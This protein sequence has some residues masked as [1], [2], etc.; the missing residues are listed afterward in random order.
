MKITSLYIKNYK[1]IR[2]I[3]IAL[4]E[5]VNVFIGENSVGKSNIFSAID[6]MLGPV[7]PSFNNFAKED[8]YRG[9]TSAHVI[10]RIHFDDNHYLELT[11][12]WHDRYGNPKS[13]LNLDGNQY[14]SDDVRQKYISALIGP[15]RK[16]SDN[17]AA[18]RWTLLGRLL[19]D[20]NSRFMEETVFDFD[21]LEE[22]EKSELFKKEM[23]R[24]R[25]DILFSVTDDEG[26]NLMQ[27]FVSILGTETAKQLN[28]T[29]DEFNVDLNS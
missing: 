5:K 12:L 25:N 6:W 9:D 8:F 2:E 4:S 23:E 15:E 22:I 20:I 17:P 26:N 10:I 27:Q 28:R 11:N 1:S 24:I 14:V 13:G 19:R 16:V 29:P 7:Y 18:N 21:T 3:N